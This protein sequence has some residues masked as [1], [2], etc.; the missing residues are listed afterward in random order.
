MTDTATTTPAPIDPEIDRAATEHGWTTTPT[1][2]YGRLYSRNAET[3]RVFHST[4][5]ARGHVC[6]S[7]R[8]FEWERPGNDGQAVSTYQGN[9]DAG[10]RATVL[11]ILAAPAK[12]PAPAIAPVVS[13]APVAGPFYVVR[14]DTDANHGWSYDHLPAAAGPFHSAAA[15]NAYIGHD[16]RFIA[17]KRAD[18]APRFRT[19][20][21]LEALPVGTLLMSDAADEGV[22]AAALR[23][24]DAGHCWTMTGHPSVMTERDLIANALTWALVRIGDE[25]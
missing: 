25:S 17:V 4:A 16:D 22:Y 21:D 11:D 6:R 20:G 2:R 13:I 19:V 10:K 12:M 23:V 18:A 3:L 5:I 7:V 15:A 14:D 24:A 9:A 1:G 8:E